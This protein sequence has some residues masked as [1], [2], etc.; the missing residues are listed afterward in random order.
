M[1]QLKPQIGEIYRHFKGNL[2]QVTGL[3]TH[4]ETGESMV[5]YQALY[6]DFA[7]FVRP[8]ELFVGEVDFEKYP[9]CTSRF[10]FTLVLKESLQSDRKG[11]VSR[12][13]TERNLTE[14]HTNVEATTDDMR[15]I[16]PTPI[17]QQP[18]E[19]LIITFLDERDFKEKDKIL[20]EIA[21]R[22]ELNNGLIDNLAA[23][24]DVVI[25]EGPLEKRFASLRT[26]VQTRARY[27][28]TRLR[29]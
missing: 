23:A 25:D 10:R 11:A 14:R 22:P 1:P 20:S 8:Y 18:I 24:I 27:E 13:A 29:G 6:G 7:T 4:S 12:P 9:E 17:R 28:N 2:Y 5:V 26:C 3:A 15:M 21:T 16:S 19:E